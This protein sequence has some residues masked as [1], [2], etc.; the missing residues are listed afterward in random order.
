MH[1]GKLQV[2]HVISGLGAGGAEHMLARLI[3][4]TPEIRHSVFS[5][6]GAGALTPQIASSG[7][8]LLG[9]AA[10]VSPRHRDFRL[11]ASYCRRVKPEIIQGW[12]YHGN[13]A[14]LYAKLLAPNAALL[15]NIRQQLP[16]PSIASV[17]TKILLKLHAKA[18]GIP[19]AIIYNSVTA[20]ESHESVG[21]RQASRVLLPNGFD[22][23]LYHPDEAARRQTRDQLG[24][25][26]N[27]VAIG[28]VA[29]FDP[30]KNHAAFFRV[31][32]RLLSTWP[33]VKFILAG[34]GTEASNPEIQALIPPAVQP[35]LRLLGDRR[36]MPSLLPALDIA[37]NVSLGEGFP[38]AVGE[39]MACGVPNV[40]TP[41]GS[42]KYLVS[43]CGLVA[44]GVDEES[45]YSALDKMLSYSSSQRRALGARSR[46]RIVSEFSIKSVA[47]QYTHLYEKIRSGASI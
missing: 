27:D 9:S 47:R 40:V 22:V 42:S 6:S 10:G 35:R 33:N 23:D 30:W 32:R 11:L 44:D 14:A 39:A 41:V 5:V 15:W 29:R 1:E 46:E 43:D 45:I 28:L 37:C 19:R 18:S 2:L 4:A 25:Q 8:S 26:E 3:A 31:A 38:N 24:L 7:G 12:M 17:P 13:I 34:N 16:P 20:A 21:V 36:D